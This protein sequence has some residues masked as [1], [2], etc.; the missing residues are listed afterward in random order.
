M[1]ILIRIYTDFYGE[2]DTT[3]MGVFSSQEMADKAV[4][5]HTA[6]LAKDYEVLL[7]GSK[8]ATIPVTLNERINVS[9]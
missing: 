9:A 1:L 7:A 3:I 4:A 8:Y 6:Y 2:N 5:E